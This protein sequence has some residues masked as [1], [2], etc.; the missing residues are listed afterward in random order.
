[1]GDAGIPFEGSR[2]TSA[3]FGMVLFAACVGCVIGFAIWALLNLAGF[4]TDL[5]WVNLGGRVAGALDATPLG[6]WWLPVVVCVVGG[7]M[8][9]LWTRLLGGSPDT[10]EA[11]MSTVKNTGGYQ[12]E[13]PGVSVVGFL[14]PLV[15]GGSIGPEAGLTG[16][17]AA[18]CTSIG[19]LLRKAGLRIAGIADLTLSASLSAVFS[20]PLVG[21]VATAQDGMPLSEAESESKSEGEKGKK[22]DGVSEAPAKPLDP[23]IHDFRRD[24]KVVLYTAAAFGAVG[25]VAL[26]TRTFG[27]STGLPS[28]EGITPGPGELLWFFPCLIVGYAGAFLFCMSS[29]GLGRLSEKLG[30]RPVLKPVLA[31]LVLGVLATFLPYVLFP[32]ESQSL[33]LMETWQVLGGGVLIATGL[34]KCVATPMCL[35]FGWRGGHFFPCIFAGIACGYGIALLSGIDPMFCV[36]ITTAA[37]VAGIQRKPMVAIAL[38]LMCFPAKSLIWMGLACIIGAA[39]PIPRIFLG[40]KDSGR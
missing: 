14:L 34:V 24:A 25:G 4:L 16:I 1:M 8:I 6:S 36:A 33:E 9:G 7:L 18:A 13:R 3:G 30:D 12:L 28:F 40:E 22:K 31:G 29:F 32:G 10:L 37:L 2:E 20:T 17:I 11:V 23:N 19:T 26:F 21:I 15:F 39:L 5:L 35:S 38:L 27:A